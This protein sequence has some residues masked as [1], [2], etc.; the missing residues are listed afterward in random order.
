MKR[1]IKLLSV[2]IVLVMIITAVMSVQPAGAIDVEVSQSAANEYNLASKCQDGMILHAWNCSYN[3]IKSHLKEI[4]AAGFTSVQTSPVQQPKDYNASWT[5][6]DGQWW[7]LYQPLSFSIAP[8]GSWLGKKAELQSL[9]N[10][11]HK[12]NIKIICDIVANHTSNNGNVAQP[13]SALRNF[14]SQLY[15]D[16]G[17]YFHSYVDCHDG[18]IENVVRGNIGLPDLNTGDSYVQSRVLSLLK[19]CID[20]G[21]DGFRFDAAKHIETPDDGY[22]ASQFWPTVLNGA[23]SYAKTK[24]NKTMYYY[25]EILNTVGNGR[26]FGSYTKYMSITDNVTGNNRTKNVSNGNADAVQSPWYN[27]NQSPDKIVLWAESHDTYADGSSKGYNQTVLDK[28]YCYSAALAGSTVLYF[29]RP[30]GGMGSF[31]STTYKSAHV[32]AVNKFHN[33][34]VGASQYTSS[35]GSYAIC[36]RYSSDATGAV[37]VNCGGTSGS[38]TGVTVNKM[39]NGTYKDAVTGS[40]ITVSSGKITSGSIGGSGVAVIYNATPINNPTNTISQAGG[41][42]TTD[43]LSLTLGLTNATSGTYQVGKGTKTT[44]TSKTTITIGK[45]MSYGQSVTITLTATDGKKTNTVT[46]TFTKKDPNDTPF[47]FPTTRTVYLLDSAKWGR[48]YCYAWKDEQNNNNQWPGIKMDVAGDLDGVVVYSYNVPSGMNNL[49]FND[50]VDQ[51]DD[52]TFQQYSY[53][54]NLT[55]KWTKVTPPV[56]PT[57]EATQKVTQKPTIDTSKLYYGDADLNKNVDIAD[58]TTI[59]MHLV[60]RISLSD[61]AIYC[62][63]VDGDGLNIADA[64]TIQ[65]YLAGIKI[66][67]PVGQ[68]VSGVVPTQKPTQKPTAA[69]E[70]TSSSGSRRVYVD[71]GSQGDTYAYYWHDNEGPVSY[72]GVRMSHISGPVYSVDVPNEYDM[73]IFSMSGNKTGDLQIPSGNNN[74]YV[75]STQTWTKYDSSYIV[76]PTVSGDLDF[77]NPHRI[78]VVDDGNWNYVSMHY[79]GSEEI[80]WPGKAAIKAGKY[81]D[82]DLYYY[83]FPETT[84]GFVIN[85]GSGN[86]SQDYFFTNSYS[87]RIFSTS[88]KDFINA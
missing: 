82:H 10:E 19:E 2:I 60:K 3:N 15:N 41:Q 61:E 80:S 87:G 81:K 13:D 75:R 84:V 71:M 33:Y 51:S 18:S 74:I 14:E 49:V 16:Q 54:D 72:P 63:D 30:A 21:V 29:M 20:C 9:C 62:G 31:N 45:D 50:E 4:A 24:S 6:V 46:Y 17:R 59:Q 69:T 76:S 57:Q 1:T 36:E 85:N 39:A 5:D 26:S 67:Y 70:P 7:K 48:A 73:I 53:F 47:K 77:S 27:S 66:K 23:T 22:C 64:T 25:G 78:Y 28:S 79:W 38:L 35:N 8:G 44:Y 65:Q 58:C 83:D 11:A 55:K 68:P 43:T 88:S 56:T 12:Y 42:F 40:S 32:S 52:L 37:I 86:Q 34:F